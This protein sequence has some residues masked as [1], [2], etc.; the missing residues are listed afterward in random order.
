MRCLYFSPS[1]SMVYHKRLL[2][3]F[4]LNSPPTVRSSIAQSTECPPEHGLLCMSINHR[5]IEI[6]TKIEQN[7]PNGR[8]KA[9]QFEFLIWWNSSYQPLEIIIVSSW[10]LS[11]SFTWSTHEPQSLTKTPLPTIQPPQDK[12]VVVEKLKRCGRSSRRRF[13]CQ[14]TTV[15]TYFWMETHNK[16]VLFTPSSSSA[17][18][19]HHRSHRFIS[20]ECHPVI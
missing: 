14:R 16:Q 2:F 6:K 20:S 13:E 8:I 3:H 17:V 15:L 11:S 9:F 12:D 19:H 5:L 10:S 7:P 18:A 4:T 1:D